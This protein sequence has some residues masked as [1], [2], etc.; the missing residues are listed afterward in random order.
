MDA[1]TGYGTA[2]EDHERIIATA[3]QAAKRFGQRA[4]AKAAR[5]SLRE[6]SAGLHG[7]KELD[8]ATL[9]KLS[10]AVSRLEAVDREQ[11]EYVQ[12][13]LEAVRERCQHIGIRKFATRAGVDGTNLARVLSGRR[14]PSQTMLAKL[15]IILA[16]N[17]K[18]LSHHRDDSSYS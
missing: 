12:K 4:L 17:S 2:P 16:Q 13:L 8:S 10:R 5:V 18:A 7:D 3:A 1:Q 15:G 9:A 6:V 14:K 11:A